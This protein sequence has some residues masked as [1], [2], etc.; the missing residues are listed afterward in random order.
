V[1]TTVA[2]QEWLAGVSPHVTAAPDW[3]LVIPAPVVAL[4]LLL[5]TVGRAKKSADDVADTMRAGAEVLTGGKV[6]AKPKAATQDQV[7]SLEADVAALTAS[8]KEQI[9]ALERK[10]DAMNAALV[11]A[12]QAQL[13]G[14]EEKARRNEAVT[15]IVAEG[16]AAAE[17]F[18]QT[19]LADGELDLAALKAEARADAER[20]A[21]KWR[22]IGALARGVNDGE[23]LSAYEEA[24]RL[25][26]GE[27]WTC[28][29][30][31][32]LYQRWK[33]DIVA[34]R[35]AAEAAERA[36]R[37]EREQ[38]VAKHE[39]GTV[40]L[41]SGDLVAARSAF[42]AYVADCERLAASNPGSAE[43]QRDL[44]ISL[45]KLG[46]VLVK[47]GDLAGAQAR[48][49]ASLGVAERLSVQN[50]GS[51]EAQRDLSV[52]LERLGD[53]LVLAGDLAGARARFEASLGVA[54]RLSVQNP[55]SAEAQRDLSV[56]LIKLGDVLVKA[57]D[58]AGARARFEASLGVLE[59]LSVQNPGSA[60]AQRDVWVTLW[61]LAELPGGGV[62][63]AQ[64]RDRLEAM[65]TRGALFPADQQFL[66]QAR[67]K[68]AAEG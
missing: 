6:G 47:A 2:G 62:T 58:L 37:G 12:G 9:A 5:W 21:E 41:T 59:R 68:A 44:S 40:L 24:H 61:R 46:E 13:L 18:E 64:V 26:P 56:S 54:E 32:R 48:F 63:W 30:L 35:R 42:E 53:V 39:L 55:G 15:G 43:A 3:A 52:S 31:C 7:K 57:G 8:Q 22:R 34:A 29:E 16:G 23:A 25:Q 10:L 28:V 45:N 14:A 4:L 38:S 33:G 20:S 1:R 17:R 51:A 19:V 66:E 50:P 60:E 11:A 67:A 27:F 65:Q 36:A 49:E